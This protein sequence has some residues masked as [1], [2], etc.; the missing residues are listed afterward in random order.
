MRIRSIKPEFW[1]SEDITDLDWEARLVFIGLWSYVDDNGVG[2]DKL[3]AITADLFAGDL[4]R[5]APETFARVSRGLETLV[6]AGRITRYQVDSKRYI[7]I[8][9]WE[10]HQRIDKP[11]RARYPSPTSE[12]VQLV[13][14]FAT[15]SRDTRETPATGTEEQRN[16]E[17]TPSNPGLDKT[18][19]QAGFEAFWAAYPRREAK[20]GAQASFARAVKNG[21]PI[22]TLVSAAVRYGAYVIAVAREREKIKIPTTWLNQGCWDDELEASGL[23][24]VVPVNPVEWLRGL[25]HD[26]DIDTIQRATRL[27]YERPDLPI[28]VDGKQ[29]VDDFFREHKR[30]WITEHHDEILA[31]LARDA[32]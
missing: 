2:M 28:G 9:N 7:H 19:I 30:A 10:K 13:I 25:W 23:A 22:E 24:P 31:R 12:N 18:N 1:R 14:E 29:A 20:K 21:T 15:S 26:G 32:A 27:R 17:K 16:R 3:H 6:H 5:D 11:N 4:E 8:T